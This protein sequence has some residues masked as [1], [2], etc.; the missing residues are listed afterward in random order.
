VIAAVVLAAGM[1]SRM[2]RDKALLRVPGGSWFLSQLA[3]TLRAGGCT[4]VVAVVGAAE[5]AIRAAVE[6][7]AIPVR[8]VR[9][10]DPARGQLSSLHA[11]MDWV[12]GSA[13]RALL[14]VPV[15]L[16]LV[17][18]HT[19][20]RVIAAWARSGAPIVRPSWRG[21][22]GHP[23]LFD[24][25]LLPELRAADLSAGARTVVRAHALEACDVEVDDPGAFD[26]IDT[27]GDYRRI[28]GVDLSDS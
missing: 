20:G 16:P 14:V 9:N 19:V 4:E 26:D 10:P 3:S 27:P 21:R 13:P 5:D 11:A 22:H 6:R 18:P 24:A 25:Q 17:A 1:S 28:F 8:L 12:A 2:G 15:D 7:E 23:V